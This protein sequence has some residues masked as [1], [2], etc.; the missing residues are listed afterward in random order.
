MKMKGY[1]IPYGYLGSSQISFDANYDRT[2]WTTV[3]ESP[4]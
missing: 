1:P 2:E 3:V 4:Y